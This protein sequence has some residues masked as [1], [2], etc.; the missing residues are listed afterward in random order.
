M[1]LRHTQNF[2]RRAKGPRLLSG[3]HLLVI[4]R[5][6]RQ[7]CP[8]RL[9]IAKQGV[10]DGFAAGTV[11]ALYRDSFQQGKLMELLQRTK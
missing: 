11:C 2:L 7:P 3:M 1:S 10:M 6:E 8:Q 4:E 5:L 9:G